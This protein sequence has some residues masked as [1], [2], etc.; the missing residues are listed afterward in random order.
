MA[1][2]AVGMK[3]FI[4]VGEGGINVSISWRKDAAVSGTVIW[5]LFAYNIPNGAN[6]NTGTWNTSQTISIN[7]PGTNVNTV[8][9]TVNITLAN[10]GLTA[11]ESCLL[12]IVRDTTDGFSG[13]A[14]L[15]GCTISEGTS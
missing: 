4:P 14:L 5:Q 8:T 12:Q 13:S 10:L 2:S 3:V 15:M 6:I 9:N 11:G 1:D 7:D